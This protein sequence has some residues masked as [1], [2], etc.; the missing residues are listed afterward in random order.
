MAARRKTEA[1]PRHLGTLRVPA[2]AGS[3][4]LV[5]RWVDEVG[6]SAGLEQGRLVCLEDAVLEACGNCV[7]LDPDDPLNLAA[8][9]RGE[10]VEIEVNDLI[11]YRRAIA[12]ATVRRHQGFGFPVMAALVDE[13]T[14]S[15]PRPG[16]TCVS[17]CMRLAG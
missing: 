3:L 16:G 6:R 2:R 7:D 12:C 14:V 4:D 15:H 11:D 17:L 8:W 10:T 13:L 1:Q 9:L 5:R